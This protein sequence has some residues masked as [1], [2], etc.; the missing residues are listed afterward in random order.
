MK[1][2]VGNQVIV[3]LKEIQKEHKS[4]SGVLIEV[5]EDSLYLQEMGESPKLFV[6]PRENV[7]YCSTDH[8]PTTK[9][10]VVLDQPRNDTAVLNNTGTQKVE[11]NVQ[12]EEDSDP[13]GIHVYVNGEY[14][15]YI[16]T[17]PT[18]RL[19]AW[20][21]N[22]VRVLANNAE[23]QHVLSGKVKKSVEYNPGEVYIS[24]EELVPPSQMPDRSPG[25][26]DNSFSMNAGSPSTT[27]LS[28][29]QMVSRLQNMSKRS[30][31]KDGE[32]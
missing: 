12:S 28:P 6:I 22:I 3:K 14:F 1:R 24:I 31:K 11:L 20:N 30:G 25:Y 17:P 27:F 5:S 8:F 26:I 4:L 7:L 21:D 18:I 32:E 2:I 13:N 29:S 10:N 15:T 19:D 16:P 9:R 23:V